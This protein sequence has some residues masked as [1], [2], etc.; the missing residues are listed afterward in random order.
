MQS[1]C[2]QG[3]LGCLESPLVK[4]PRDSRKSTGEW[5]TD[6]SFTKDERDLS[7]LGGYMPTWSQKCGEALS[8]LLIWLQNYCNG[9]LLHNVQI[10]KNGRS[11]WSHFLSLHPTTIP[12]IRSKLFVPPWCV[13]TLQGYKLQTALVQPRIELRS[14][15]ILPTAREL[16]PPCRS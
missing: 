10:V 9:F 15:G 4:S 8:G 3:H 1:A 14:T 11:C 12:S 7:E 13:S 6:N 5:A 16:C 2:A